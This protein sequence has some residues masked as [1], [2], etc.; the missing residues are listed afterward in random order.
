M[1]HGPSSPD[2][3]S[4]WKVLILSSWLLLGRPAENAS[5]A[6]CA[7]H[8]EAR[9]D[10][11]WSEEWR[12]LWAMVRAE[13][14]VTTA[15]RKR[16]RTQAEQTETRIRKVAT[17]ARA[18]EKGRALAAA[19][20]A[21]PVLVTQDKVQEITS[22]YPVD[23][24]PAIPLNNE[25]THIF[26]FD[27]ADHIPLTP[28]RMPRLSE[29]GPL[30]MRA[31][32][33]Y[34]F[35]TQAGDI[36]TFALVMAHIATATLPDAVLQ[37]LRAGQV[38]LLAKPTGGHRPL[39]VLSFSRPLAL[40]AVIAAKQ[41]SVIRAAGALQYGVGSADGANKMIKSI[42]YFAEADQSRMLVALDPKAAFQ[43]VSRRSML[44]SLGNHD[45]ELATVFSRWYTGS[46]THRMHHNGAYAHIQAS[47]GIDQGCPPCGFAAA[48]DPISQ[49]ILSQIQ[50]TLDNG[51]K[52]W[53]YLDDWYI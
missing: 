46:T 23:P 21:P 50:R 41:E 5:D 9:L 2:S 13:C 18:G 44:R 7:S 35:G 47:S 11:F 26:L 32:R 22:L 40:K 27:I 19:R 4:A 53:A 51:A 33:W 30:G 42:Q 31:E 8:M 16:T 48:V 3:Q 14:D 12:A 28:K 49:Y 29:P 38:T 17:L 52:L 20:N 34:D 25:I 43:N 37:Y 10:L 36:S 15:T 24:D 1:H 6:N 39:L 45:P